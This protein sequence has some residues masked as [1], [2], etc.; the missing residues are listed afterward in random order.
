MEV[1]VKVTFDKQELINSDT[2]QAD[3]I[4]KAIND[5]NMMLGWGK[6]R[7]IEIES[8]DEYHP[9]VNIGG[10]K[11]LKKTFMKLLEEEIIKIN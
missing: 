9:I 4:T 10:F 2:F 3:D 1:N 11:I 5:F 8:I 7:S 6:C